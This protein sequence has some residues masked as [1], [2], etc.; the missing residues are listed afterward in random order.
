MYVRINLLINILFLVLKSIAQNNTPAELSR[1]ITQHI[2][3]DSL[4]VAAIYKWV[5]DNIFYDYHFRRREEGDTTL[6]QEPEQVILRKKGVCIGY[7][8]LINRL[9]AEQGIPSVVIEGYV[10]DEHGNFAKEEHAWNAVKINQNWYLLDATWGADN[11]FAAKLYFLTPP[12]V[13]IKNHLPHDPL[14]QISDEPITFDCFAYGNNCGVNPMGK[15]NLLDSLS[16]W[17][18]LDTIT[19]YLNEGIRRLAFNPKDIRAMRL[20]AEFYLGKATELFLKYTQIREDIKNKKRPPTGKAEVLLLLNGAS[21]FL[22]LT[23]TQYENIKTYAKKNRYTDAHLNIELIEE[24]LANLENEKEF[25][26][27]YFKD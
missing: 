4:K 2:K 7:S 17:E 3:D 12:N 22:N 25:V 19:R 27:K 1:E 6:Y 15:F 13:F 21:Q 24:N 11:A 9:C 16:Q 14:W 10:K 18:K 26:E 23:K 20:M 5:T 8:K